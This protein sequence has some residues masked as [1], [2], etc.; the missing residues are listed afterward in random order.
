[1][2][3]DGNIFFGPSQIRIESDMNIEQYERIRTGAGFIA[4]LDQSGGSTPKALA[5][6]GV[7][8]SAYS[9]QEQMYL[10]MH[11]MRVRIMTSRVFTSERILATIL[12]EMTM[13]RLVEGLPTANYLWH[14]K[15]IV[16]FLKIDNGLAPRVNGV[17]LMK[18]IPELVA[19]L[20]RANN[21]GIFGTKARSV[22]YEANAAGISAC[23]DQ[24]F[25]VA[26]QV[27]ESDLVP[28]IEP[29]VDIKSAEKHQVEQLLKNSLLEALDALDSSH[30]VILKLTPPDQANYYCDLIQHPRVIRVAML[31]GGYSQLQATT[32]LRQNTDVIASFSRALTEGL[33]TNQSEMEFEKVLGESIESI[34]QASVVKS[35]SE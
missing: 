8:E 10:L 14:R 32:L 29:E 11:Q 21:S 34:Y 31:S 16:P 24:Q 2:A 30:N 27:L 12:F 4:A 13:E 23:V 19:L 9:N 6:F 18:P 28:I 15:G 25:E 26:E 3:S 17:S 7:N 22:I 20:G 5:L 35:C 33:N 1:V